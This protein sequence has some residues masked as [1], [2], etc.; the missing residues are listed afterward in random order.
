MSQ[1]PHNYVINEK[2]SNTYITQF[3]HV[4][5]APNHLLSPSH[6]PS[7]QSISA[8]SI[9]SGQR[10]MQAAVAEQLDPSTWSSHIQSTRYNYTK[11]CC[12]LFVWWSSYCHSNVLCW[13]RWSCNLHS[14]SKDNLDL[15]ILGSSHCLDWQA[16][17]WCCRL[18]FAFILCSCHYS[19][20]NSLLY[21][22]AS[23]LVLF[24]PS[25]KMFVPHTVAISNNPSCWPPHRNPYR[26]LCITAALVI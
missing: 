14:G 26:F 11:V 7:E 9:S 2:H 21:I 13:D 6:C 15:R 18:I 19:R 22:H 23:W 24:V 17:A 1:A 10:R 20:T 5:N 8:Q 4:A 25:R 12:I 3:I 16:W